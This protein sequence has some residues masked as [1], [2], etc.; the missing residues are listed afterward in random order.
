MSFFK[1]PD[2]EFQ[3]CRSFKAFLS[4][5]LLIAIESFIKGFR[6]FYFSSSYL[7]DPPITLIHKCPFKNN[8]C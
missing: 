8:V 2:S 5:V 4:L 1:M 3:S 6:Y 7:A